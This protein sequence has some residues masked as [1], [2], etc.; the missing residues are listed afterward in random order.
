M[1]AAIAEDAG[2]RSSRARRATPGRT[3]VRRK[4]QGNLVTIAALGAAALAGVVGWA[5]HRPAQAPAVVAGASA[6][7]APVRVAVP[8]APPEARL[9]VDGAERGTGS[10]SSA[11]ASASATAP[12]SRTAAPRLAAHPKAPAGASTAADSPCAAPYY[13]VNGI[14]TFKPECL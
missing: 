10:A 2:S 6:V 14:K 3:S 7:A 1:L 12:P 8:A 5:L 11:A 9:E 13:F 4:K